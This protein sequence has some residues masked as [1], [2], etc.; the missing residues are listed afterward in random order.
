MLFLFCMLKAQSAIL[1]ILKELEVQV[2]RQALKGP[3]VYPQQEKTQSKSSLFLCWL[4][5]CTVIIC[6]GAEST[7]ANCIW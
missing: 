7:Q 4:R 5:K 6:G 3:P 2:D 1:F